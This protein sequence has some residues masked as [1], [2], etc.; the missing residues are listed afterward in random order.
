MVQLLHFQLDVPSVPANSTTPGQHNDHITPCSSYRWRKKDLLIIDDIAFTGSFSDPPHEIPTLCSIPDG[1][2]RKNVWNILLA[3][4]IFMLRR[5]I[6]R[7]LAH[8]P[9]NLNSLLAY[10]CLQKYFHAHPTDCIGLS[11]VSLI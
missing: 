8:H 3:N 5:N 6:E 4:Q 1:I 11:F 2:Y 10:F 7:S 9:V